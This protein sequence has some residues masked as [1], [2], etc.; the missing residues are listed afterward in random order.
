MNYHGFEHAINAKKKALRNIN[1]KIEGLEGDETEFAQEK[2]AN[3][4]REEASTRLTLNYLLRLQAK[5][6]EVET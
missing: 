5:K 6:E 4:L 1:G 2:R 3:L